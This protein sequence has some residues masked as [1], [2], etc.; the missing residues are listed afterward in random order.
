ME[1]T[2]SENDRYRL[3]ATL[4]KDGVW[5]KLIVDLYLGSLEEIG[6]PG[7]SVSTLNC[8]LTNIYKGFSTIETG[9]DFCKDPKLQKLTFDRLC[10]LIIGQLQTERVL[11][12]LRTKNGNLDE[13]DSVVGFIAECMLT[14]LHNLSY[15]YEPCVPVMREKDMMAVARRIRHE[16]TDSDVKTL[17]LLIIAY[18][19]DES[20]DKRMMKITE[21]ELK[22]LL[23]ELEKAL[24]ATK[25]SDYHP[26]EL[27]DGLNR[28]AVSDIN[29]LKL[30]E[31]GILKWLEKSLNPL[32]KFT[33]PHRAAA[34]RAVW[35]LA[36]SEE[37]R[38]E[39]KQQK[40]LMSGR[41]CK[42]ASRTNCAIARHA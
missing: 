20:D 16:C 27:I 32:K 10:D 14:I 4:V 22:Y 5:F 28:I 9:S 36:F 30:M 12:V 11:S 24:L 21:D 8:A 15:Y 33:S 29:K 26:E 37:S 19:M 17:C 41:L 31:C 35:N 1:H 13:I 39:I 6:K 34:A 25:G 40:G 38:K 3:Y 42:L 2:I 18:L 23:R 7:V